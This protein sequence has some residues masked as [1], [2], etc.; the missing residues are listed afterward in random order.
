MLRFTIR[1]LLWLMVVVAVC[2]AWWV[3]RSRLE[4]RVV[5]AEHMHDDY[6]KMLNT[7][8]PNWRTIGYSDGQRFIPTAPD[9]NQKSLTTLNHA[10]RG[11]DCF[12]GWPAAD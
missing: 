8:N 4:G 1:D 6:V 10:L 11:R 7:L 3:D 5:R 12:S 2:S 9:S